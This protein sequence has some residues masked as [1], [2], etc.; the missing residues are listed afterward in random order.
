M[1]DDLELQLVD[2]RSCMRP[3]D[4]PCSMCGVGGPHPFCSRCLCCRYCSS[5]CQRAHW[6]SIHREDCRAFAAV[7]GVGDGGHFRP[8]AAH[9]SNMLMVLYLMK[10]MFP[11][12]DTERKL[13][14]LDSDI[15]GTV[16]ENSGYE[17][18]ECLAM[19]VDECLSRDGEWIPIA[20]H[21]SSRQ[22]YLLI[23]A[24]MSRL[25]NALGADSASGV[26][27]MDPLGY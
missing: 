25:D 23:V 20:L 22:V 4:G 2:F 12:H 27:R 10:L 14:T 19:K 21:L 17:D 6:R 16:T 13:R 24:V 3:R 5:A 11:E 9:A 18:M 1:S 15:E 8:F 7:L 26:S